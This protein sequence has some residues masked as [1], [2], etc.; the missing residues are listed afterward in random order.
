MLWWGGGVMVFST[1]FNNIS[2][3]WWWSVLL[4]L[5]QVTDKLYHIIYFSYVFF[6]HFFC[7]FLIQFFFFCVIFLGG[8]FIVLNATFK[9][10]SVI[11]WHSV[12]MRH[13]ASNLYI[14]PPIGVRTISRLQAKII[15]RYYMYS[16]L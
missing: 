7:E 6:V 12:L 9:N 11:S 2:V 3:V 4:D 16:L 1:T 13:E 5:S 8:W 15:T 14:T 10:I